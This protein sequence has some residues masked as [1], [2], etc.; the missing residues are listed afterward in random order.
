[1]AIEVPRD[2]PSKE[3]VSREVED[4]ILDI[5]A[6]S[7]EEPFHFKELLAK[8]RARL[9]GKWGWDLETHVAYA[10]DMLHT[11]SLIKRVAPNTYE[12]P[13]GPDDVY[14]ERATGHAP[15]G[16]F[17][18]R[19]RDFTRDTSNPVSKSDWRHEMSKADLSVKMLKN[20]GKDE[21]TIRSM[22]LSGDKPFN[23]VAVEVAIKKYFHGIEGE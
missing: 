19:G 11:N 6:A 3:K 1:M 20:M 7:P 8:I 16:E 12:S 17:V 5:V 2:K 22:L 18:Q 21:A 15:E 23:R 10:L 4:A 14:S 9:A 13:E